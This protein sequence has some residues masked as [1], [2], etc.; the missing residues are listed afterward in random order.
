M[1]KI[2]A[3]IQ[4]AIRT[5]TRFKGANTEIVQIENIGVDSS[6]LVRFH[7]HTIAKQ[8]SQ[9]RVWSFCFCGYRT[10]TTRDRINAVR[11]ALGLPPV[12]LTQFRD[13]AS[14]LTWFN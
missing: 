1:R 9:S 7:G 4:N 5:N 8:C 12:S 10:N 14:L 11:G 2:T 3:D 13:G 6:L